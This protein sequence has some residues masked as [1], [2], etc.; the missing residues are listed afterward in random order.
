ME[1]NFIKEVFEAFEHYR[2]DFKKC[3]ITPAIIESLEESAIITEHYIRY[4]NN[5]I[6]EEHKKT[7]SAI[8]YMN[9]CVSCSFFHS[10][11]RKNYT[12]FG[13]IAYKIYDT[14][15]YNTSVKTV[16]TYT[17]KNK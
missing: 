16:R 8:N 6:Q 11:V 7:I 13:N 17:F 9:V 10:R 5:A 2:K 15:P 4:E 12:A 3:G 14:N 1:N